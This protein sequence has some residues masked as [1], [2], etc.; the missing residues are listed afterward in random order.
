[1]TRSRLFGA[2]TILLVTNHLTQPNGPIEVKQAPKAKSSYRAR[3][4][5]YNE[6]M[7]QVADLNGLTIIDIEKAWTEG[8]EKVG[9]GGAML[10]PDGLHLSLDG[11][12]FYFGVVN[13]ICLHAARQFL[14]ELQSA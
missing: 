2:S 7:R 8:P 4:R 6:I 3:I 1:I 9:R 10:D 13:P 5:E 12:D 14:P 11:H